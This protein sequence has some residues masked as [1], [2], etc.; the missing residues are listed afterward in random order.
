[1]GEPH[2]GSPGNSKGPSGSSGQAAGPCKCDFFAG[3]MIHFNEIMHITM[4]KLHFEPPGGS[5]GPPGVGTKRKS[6]NLVRQGVPFGGCLEAFGEKKVII[7][8][9]KVKLS[10]FD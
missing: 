3:K 10:T 2:F 4:G 6:L 5:K 1:M 7:M 9:G 8:V